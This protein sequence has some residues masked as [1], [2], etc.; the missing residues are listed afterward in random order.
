MINKSKKQTDSFRG[1]F[2]Y[3]FRIVSC[4]PTTSEEA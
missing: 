3:P 1:V 4:F 2:Q